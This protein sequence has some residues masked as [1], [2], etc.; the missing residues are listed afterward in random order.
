MDSTTIEQKPFL[1]GKEDELDYLD[2]PRNEKG[3]SQPR[4]IK[5]HGVLFILQVTFLALNMTFLIWNFRSATN[6]KNSDIHDGSLEEVYCES[7]KTSN[8]HAQF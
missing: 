7:D 6:D 1:A 8:I 2:I 3:L 5:T 4:F